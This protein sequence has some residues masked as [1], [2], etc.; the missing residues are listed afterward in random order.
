MGIDIYLP[1]TPKETLLAQA[2]GEFSHYVLQ[3]EP[4]LCQHILE[5]DSSGTVGELQGGSDDYS[6]YRVSIPDDDDDD[7]DD[8]CAAVT[9]LQAF[10]SSPQ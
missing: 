4:Y 1:T 3:D 5:K 6:I 10:H 7:D 2:M 9:L 8:D